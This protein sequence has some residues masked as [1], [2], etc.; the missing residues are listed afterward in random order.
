[1]LLYIDAL[2]YED[3]DKMVAFLLEHEVEMVD[4][5]KVKMCVLAE[6]TPELVKQMKKEVDF[7]DPISFGQ[8]PLS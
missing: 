1:M 6:T 5:N 7:K 3:Y 4:R 2:S 8:K